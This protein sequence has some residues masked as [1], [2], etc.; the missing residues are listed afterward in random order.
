MSLH[1]TTKQE[2]IIHNT[3]LTLDENAASWIDHP[4]HLESISSSSGED[5][6]EF[7]IHDHDSAT[8]DGV[9]EGALSLLLALR[10][11]GV[12]IEDEKIRKAMITVLD[13]AMNAGDNEDD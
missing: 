8:Y 2:I 6:E 1:N 10:S 7:A 12:V 9:I 4:L 3:K 5:G 11:E 13:A